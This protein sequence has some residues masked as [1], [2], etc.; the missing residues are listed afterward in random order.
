MQAMRISGGRPLSGHIAISGAK[1]AA[2]P[3]LAASLLATEPVLLR[4]MPNVVDIRTMANLLANI[5]A[6]VEARPDSYFISAA[7]DLDPVAPYEL[8]KTMRASSLVLGPLAARCGRARVSL[9]GGCAIGS[10]PID[11]HLDGLKT[12]GAAVQQDRGYI[13]AVAPSG[14]LIGGRI[15]F[16]RPTVTGTEDLLMAATLANGESVLENAACEPEVVDLA[17]LLTKMGARIEG[18]GTP[19][20]RVCGVPELT[21]AEH[22]IIPDRIETGTYLVAGA[23]AGGELTLDGTC[24]HHLEPVIAKMRQAGCLIE[25]PDDSTLVLRQTP[26]LISVDVT[27]REHP[28][29]PTDMQAQFMA[30]MTQAEGSSNV[31]E[32]VFENRFMHALELQRMGADITIGGNTA[33]VRGKAALTGTD[34][35]ASDL[36]ASA[37]LVLAGLAA[38]GTTTVH[39]IYHLQRGYD[40]LAEKLSGV[41][42]SIEFINE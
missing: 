26:G 28:G 33:V 17:D 4:R 3:A 13:E 40:R 36:R 20:I 2:L 29:F 30:L 22:A 24:R 10:R 27:T 21:G 1:N 31:V 9:P 35:M 15:Q 16:R 41:G 25:S 39:R 18:A 12:L 7:G 14:G 37:S 32:T 19:T 6:D 42:A 8:V 23:I 38:N 34:V 11:M 5:G